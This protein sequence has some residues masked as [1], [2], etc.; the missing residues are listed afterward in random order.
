MSAPF[1]V[2]LDEAMLSALDQLAEKTD[3]SRNWLVARAIEDFVALN[4]WQLG[5]IETGIAA[6]DRGD[7]ASDDELARIRTKFAPRP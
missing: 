3:R 2:R 7:F 6:A 1:T 4:A 5:K